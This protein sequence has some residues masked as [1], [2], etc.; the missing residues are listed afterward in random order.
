MVG[1]IFA[2]YSAAIILSSPFVG[3]AIQRFGTNK[4][5]NGGLFSMGLCFFLLAYIQDMKSK[6]TILV[7]ALMLR[8]FQGFSSAS[9]QT[10]CYVI[11]T[12]NYPENKETMIGYIEAVMGLGLILGPI[13]GSILYA[14]FGFSKTFFIYGT[15]LCT[16]ALIMA[17]YS[18]GNSSKLE[19]PLINQ[20]ES[21]IMQ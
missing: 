20:D 12:N 16:F 5:I 4:L 14:T 3:S 18:Q 21:S 1:F 13:I 6:T 10:T 8:L 15:F 11:A 7:Y 19:Q 17:Y 9:V 2:I